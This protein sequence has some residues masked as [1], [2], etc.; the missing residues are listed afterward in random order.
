MASFTTERLPFTAAVWSVVLSDTSGTFEPSG[1]NPV[2]VATFTTFPARISASFTWYDA[3]S[4][5]DA[6]GASDSIV[7][8]FSVRGSATLISLIV[9]LPL[10]VTVIVYLITCPRAYIPFSA[11]SLFVVTF[12]I[13]RL[14][15]WSTSTISVFSK[16]L[17]SSN[18]AVTV[19]TNFPSRISFSVIV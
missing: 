10:F 11:L 13:V 2:A 16:L 8:A 4:S 7:H 6:P 9:R 17:P 5:L 12:S 18:V 3:V 19:L 1:L 15:D 14:A